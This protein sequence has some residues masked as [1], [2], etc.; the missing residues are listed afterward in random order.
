MVKYNEIASRNEL[1]DFLGIE[2]R[3]LTYVLYH[4]KVE[5]CYR[6]FEIP[7]KNGSKR[8]INAPDERLKPI[9]KRLASALAVHQKHVRKEK[10]IKANISHAFEKK[11]SIFSN[12]KIH[13]NRRFVINIDLKDFFDSFNFGRVRGF[14]M[15]NEDF[16]VPEDVATVI[17]QIACYE[18]KLPQ[19]SPSSPV[20]TNLICQILDYRLLK[21]AS[22]H[23][24]DYTR[25]ADDMTF[26]TNSRDFPDHLDRFLQDVTDVVSRAG[27]LINEDKTRLQL[28]D[29][30]QS[31]TG[32]VV[33]KK[34][35]TRFEYR[36]NTRTMAYCLYKTGE[37]E[38]DEIKGS[39][40]QLEGR[41]SF[42][43]QVD[44]KG[45][46]YWERLIE[47]RKLQSSKSFQHS[48]H[49]FTGREKG[50]QRFLFYKNF[51]N[52][53]KP[54]VL[55][56]GKT[57][58]VHLRAA[59]KNLYK[60]YPSLISRKKDGS[61]EYKIAFHKRTSKKFEYYFG[62]TAG[63][64]AS[65]SFYSYF[66]NRDN[67][68]KVPN[69]WKYFNDMCPNVSKH[70]V[71][72]LFDNELVQGKPVQKF[73]NVVSGSDEKKKTIM[74]A[75]KKGLPSSILEDGNLYLMTVPKSV[76]K[77]EGDIEDLYE[78]KVLKTKIKGR[79][80]SRK[81]IPKS[82]KHYGKHELSLYVNCNYETINFDEFRPLFDA[83]IE[84]IKDYKNTARR[85]KR[86]NS[87]I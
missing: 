11:K 10:N 48:D 46:R 9:Q 63:A 50:Y 71:I 68:K 8:T 27:F 77:K 29:S 40:E 83:L 80:F 87:R 86:R 20:I 30:R 78:S 21:V 84:V 69:Y 56:E 70:P 52:H 61:F 18:G 41:F 75:L 73:I 34:L 76:T 44:S 25:Y 36:R 53:D 74:A 7:K 23:K 72:L 51:Y 79:L 15:K 62:L 54:V 3:Y 66:T 16:M 39:M 38:I 35:N 42:I 45:L 49:V 81:A 59:L 65:T 14:F 6:K 5:N 12:A 13:R 43:D 37:F 85:L 19:G 82:T 26:S 60:D 33:N 17:A 22:E 47:A 28:R 55:T 57:D 64:D 58:T 31:V 2:R 67:N 24:V 4:L 1:A 32:L